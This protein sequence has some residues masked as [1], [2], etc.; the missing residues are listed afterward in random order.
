MAAPLLLSGLG[1]MGPAHAGASS[2]GDDCPILRRGEFAPQGASSPSS[3]P[4]VAASSPCF[5]PPSGGAGCAPSAWPRRQRPRCLVFLGLASAPKA[6]ASAGAIGPGGVLPGSCMRAARHWPRG[7]GPHRPAAC[8]R[9]RC[10]GSV[11]R[12]APAAC[13]CESGQT[14]RFRRAASRR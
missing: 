10:E 7:S 3:C 8:P 5:R 6:A 13:H 9:R 1:P 2:G 11:R 4:G 12:I 14:G